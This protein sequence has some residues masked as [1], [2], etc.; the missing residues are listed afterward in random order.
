MLISSTDNPR[1]R[2]W[3]KL[4]QGKYR[5]RLQLFI[6]EQPHMIEEAISAGVLDTLLVRE[7]VDNRFDFP[8]ITVSD[9]VM[10]KLSANS[11][12]ND[13]LGICHYLKQQQPHGDCFIVLDN[14][15][16]PGNVGTII[17]TAHC[18]GYD[19]IFMNKG[20]AG[21][22]NSKTVQSSQGALFHIP[23]MIRDT[24]ETISD[25]RKMGVSVTATSLKA[26]KSLQEKEKKERFALVFG[27]EGQGLT[28]N[29][30][31]VCDDLVRIEMQNFDSLNVAVAM[32]ICSFVMKNK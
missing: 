16:D 9:S 20:C 27:N 31:D 4:K 18:L 21:L 14:V 17:R 11:S 22:Y 2:E 10:K 8:C 12:L 13:Y 1:V 25:L 29:I 19:G 15:Q 26:E 32:G 7:S 3:D 24:V 5:D 28:Q 30:E 23:I 6:V